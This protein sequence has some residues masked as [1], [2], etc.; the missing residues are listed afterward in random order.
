MTNDDP[1]ENV[2]K[3]ELWNRLRRLEKAVLP[4]RRDV[5]KAGGAAG[6]AGLLGFNAGSASGADTSGARAGSPGNE[7]D[8]YLDE[9]KD[10]SG[11]VVADIDDTGAVD[12]QRPVST[13]DLS[14]NNI[15]QF[16]EWATISDDSTESFFVGD[17]EL[18]T[19]SGTYSGTGGFLITG[20]NKIE[21]S[22]LGTN[23]TTQGNTSLSGTTG[24]DD[25]L[26]IAR[27]DN[28]LI[29]ENRLGDQRTFS[30]SAPRRQP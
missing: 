20:Y 9:I 14:I 17:F 23:T 15:P 10:K 3:E 5:L 2:T 16:S 30:V 18:F 7:I 8:V 21:N 6:A 29:L 1:P 26:N 24:P 27:N 19:I 25:S 22:L 4:S 11:D 28:T 12:F 13:S